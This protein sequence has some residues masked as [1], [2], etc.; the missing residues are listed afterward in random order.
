MFDT[1]KNNRIEFEEFAV[2]MSIICRGSEEERAECKNSFRLLFILQ[3]MFRV[4]DLDG[5]GSISKSE[6]TRIAEALR[7]NPATQV[8][9]WLH[10]LT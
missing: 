10:F 8:F 4:I 3:V 7:S 1:N 6:F 9:I 5:N 2:G